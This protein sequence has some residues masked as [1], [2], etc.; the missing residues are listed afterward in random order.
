MA[1]GGGWWLAVS[2]WWRLAVGR[3]S[4]GA[5][6]NKE[7][8]PFL[9]TALIAPPPPPEVNMDWRPVRR[10]AAKVDQA[11]RLLAIKAQYVCQLALSGVRSGSGFQGATPQM[12]QMVGVGAWEWVRCPSAQG[13]L[14][15]LP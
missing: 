9:K 2:G 7:I 14:V 12:A 10:G 15:S 5:V 1:V 11:C 6:L 8:L 4:F 3:W 13:P